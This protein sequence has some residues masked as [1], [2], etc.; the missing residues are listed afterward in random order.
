MVR[1]VFYDVSGNNYDGASLYRRKIL[2]LPSNKHSNDSHIIASINSVYLLVRRK[3]LR[4]YRLT[5]PLLN[6]RNKATACA[7]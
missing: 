5:P 6:M 3:I 4:L 7:D 1:P 2:R